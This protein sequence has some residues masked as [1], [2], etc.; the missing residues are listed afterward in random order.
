MAGGNGQDTYEVNDKNDKVIE[1]AGG[2]EDRVCL[3][4][5]DARRE[6]RAFGPAGRPVGIGNGLNN[7]IQVLAVSASL[8]GLAGNDVD[9][10]RRRQ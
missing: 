9:Y 2:G 5:H 8:S 3:H 1:G 4:R 7:Q 10:R 6:C